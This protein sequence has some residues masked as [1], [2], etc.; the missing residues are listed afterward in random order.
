MVERGPDD[1]EGLHGKSTRR[2][3]REVGIIGVEQGLS[4]ASAMSC[5]LAP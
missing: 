3:F 5:S 2:G 4:E 1:V